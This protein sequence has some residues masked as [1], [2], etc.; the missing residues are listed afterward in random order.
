MRRMLVLLGVTVAA[1][2]VTAPSALAAAGDPILVLRPH[3]PKEP[4]VPVEPPPTG[5]FEGP[6]GLAVD[7][8]G[9]FYVADYYHHQVDQYSKGGGY[10]AQIDAVDPLD[11][12][13]GLAIDAS[14]GVYVNNFHRNVVRFD[15]VPATGPPTVIAG[16]GTDLT[17]P[18]GVAVDRVSGLVYVDERTQVGVFDA[19]GVRTD[20]VGAGAIEDGYG[21]AVS[22]YPA[23]K[24]FVYVPD[25]A[26][27]TVKVFNPAGAETPVQTI[28]GNEVPGGGFVSLRNAAIAIDDQ[29]GEV[30]VVDD[31]TPNYK[32]G[33]EGVVYVFGTS[34]SYKG[35]LKY[36]IENGLPAGLAIDNTGTESQ[37]R[38]YVTTGYSELAA[39]YAFPPDSEGEAAVPLGGPRPPGD[40]EPWP[41]GPPVVTPPP[42]LSP[43]SALVPLAAS[44]PASAT[45]GTAS[46]AASSP[47]EATAKRRQARRKQRA[48][49][50]HKRHAAAKQRAA[51]S[52]NR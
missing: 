19:A 7:P 38:V 2:A 5:S 26:T 9:R 43:P 28:D 16:V 41:P 33:H 10:L 30:Y 20:T 14:G 50:R 44:A 34:G 37:G 8:S 32:E 48:H 3:P 18:T 11:G 1:L 24:G 29:S 47:S 45:L 49:A 51:R 40:E 31:L 39:V 13:C 25:A 27:D 23:T 36:S 12:P 22:N 52:R 17:H 21:I 42:A 6:C 15:A 46:P 35:R 4:G